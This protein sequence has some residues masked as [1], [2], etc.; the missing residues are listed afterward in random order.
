[1]NNYKNSP[2]DICDTG[3]GWISPEGKT[4]GVNLY[5][6]LYELFIW[7]EL[8]KN[9]AAFKLVE[10]FLINSSAKIYPSEQFLVESECE[11]QEEIELCRDL[12][13]IGFIKISACSI[14]G[15]IEAEGNPAFLLSKLALLQR[16][17]R[18]YGILHNNENMSINFNT[19]DKNTLEIKRFHSVKLNADFI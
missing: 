13:E 5:S 16:I 15:V 8:I 19:I 10:D 11:C 3:R 18:D 7:I 2:I 12:Y 14:L 6:H 17:A 4:L 1:M 9:T